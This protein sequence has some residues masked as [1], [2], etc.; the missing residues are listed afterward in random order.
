MLNSQKFPKQ[1]NTEKRWPI[2]EKLNSQTEPLTVEQLIAE[3]FPSSL[4]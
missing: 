2:L 4:V 1:W 3:E